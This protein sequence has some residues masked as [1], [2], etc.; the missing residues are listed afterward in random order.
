M[1]ARTERPLRADAQRNRDAIV[2][3][4]GQAFA[5]GGTQA[6]LDDIA[7]RAGVGNATLYRHFPTRDS[8]LVAALHLRLA[9]LDEI[10]NRLAEV[11][12][13]DTA[14]REWFFAA[15]D[16]LRTWSGLPDSVVQAL[17]SDD[18]PLT[19]ACQPL[20]ATTGTFVDRAKA[21][22]L[23]RPQLRA[24]DVFTIVAALA[25]AADKR[26]DTDDDLRRMIDT[27]LRGMYLP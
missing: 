15:A 10:A 18:S 6:S 3:A 5:E 4:A 27:V 12:D 14:L 11:G 17:R 8:L 22:G 1:P 9:E 24:A 7:V 16:H 20:R 25:W 2:A 23:F 19:D 13:L 21:A 26:G